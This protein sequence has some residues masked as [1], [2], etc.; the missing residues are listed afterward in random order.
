[1][2]LR[3][4]LAT[5][6]IAAVLTVSFAAFAPAQTIGTFRWQQ[7]PYCNVLSLTVTQNGALYELNGF[8]DQ[9]GAATRAAVTGLGVLNP[10]GT[11]GFGLTVITSPGGSPL[12]IDASLSLATLG[13][14][15]RDTTN[16]SGAWTF[17][18]GPALPGLSRPAPRTAFPGG[19]ALGGQTITALGTPVQGT[20]AATKAYVDTTARSIATLTTNVSAFGARVGAGTASDVASGCL[21]FGTGAFTQLQLDLP[22]P[23]GAVPSSVVMKYIDTSPNSFT[24]DV[25]TYVVQDGQ[26]RQDNSA[27]SITSTNGTGQGI[28]VIT[29]PTPTAQPVSATRGYYVIVTAGSYVTGDLGFCGAQVNYTLP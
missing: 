27:G 7:Q 13:G 6:A 3:C 2:R 24:L 10:N 9:C 8:D 12:H 1:M 5:F 26:D 19:I 17:L 25:R 21:R 16:S 28:R 4:P 14:S 29:V 20:D 15:W 11:I 23:F 22:L 18:A